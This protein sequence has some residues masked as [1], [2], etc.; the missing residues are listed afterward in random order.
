MIGIFSL[1]L[2]LTGIRIIGGAIGKT[3]VTGSNIND[4]NYD[5]EHKGLRC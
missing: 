5:R 3:L 2:I 4:N 1:L